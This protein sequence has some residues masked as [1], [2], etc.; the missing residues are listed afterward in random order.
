M[1]KPAFDF[2]A[3]SY[4]SSFART[5]LGRA[6]REIVQHNLANAFV[7]GDRVL[8]L[9]CGT[10]EDAVWLAQ[11]GIDVVATDVSAAMLDCAARKA[12]C[13]GVSARIGFRLL[14]ISQPVA[15][16]DFGFDGALSDFG[17]LNC[18]PDL[19]PV[20][21]MLGRCIKPGGTWFAV[22]LG[23]WCAWEILWHLVHLEPRTA[24]RR[25]R[26]GGA[27]ARVGD[28]LIRVWYPSVGKLKKVF[29]PDFELRS[30]AGVGV[31]LPPTYLEAVIAGRK[32]LSRLLARLERSLLSR[33]FRR[34]GDHILL[35]FKRC[36]RGDAE[37]PGAAPGLRR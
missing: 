29:A 36:R 16:P 30:T 31:F 9:N 20:A 25:L 23:R 21:E 7:P 6:L 3:A 24:F 11:R 19:E 28:R 34:F 35:E 14:D 1:I 37:L 17:G 5:G 12:A 4:D 26:A 8:E 22:V 15:G 32:N 2:V 18:V 13:A 33:C 27:E 10:G